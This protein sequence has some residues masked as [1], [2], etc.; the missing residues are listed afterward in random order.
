[1][2]IAQ[3][4]EI[5]KLKQRV[6]RLE[7]KRKLK[8]SGFKRL[9]KVGT[10]QRVESSADTVIDDQ[11]DETDEAEPAEVEEVLEVV[12]ATKLMIEVVTTSTTT[13]TD[14]LVP[15]ASALRKRRGVII[16]DPKEAATAS[17]SMQSKVKSIDKTKG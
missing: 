13:I 2:K 17:L 9:R 4:I 12:T 8:A 6:R 14:A 16:Q 7:K 5:T 1:D 11:E 3:D 15:K 10:A